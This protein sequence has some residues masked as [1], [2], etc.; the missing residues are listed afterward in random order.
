[1]KMG[2]R[3]YSLRRTPLARGSNPLRRRAPLKATAKLEGGEPLKRRTRLNPINRERKAR[4]YAEQFGPEAEVIRQLPCVACG[5][6]APSIPHHVKS[7]GAG[8]RREAQVPLCQSDP[9]FGYLGC[10]E[11]LHAVGRR[12]FELRHRIDLARVAAVLHAAPVIAC[13]HRR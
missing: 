8:G 4:L 1:M 12:T 5:H 10:H 9:R 6:E 3:R 13:G 2:M 11:E 7:R